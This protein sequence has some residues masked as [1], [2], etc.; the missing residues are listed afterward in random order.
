MDRVFEI[1]TDGGCSGN[2]GPG[3]WA[4]VL[5]M[6]DGDDE[7]DERISGGDPAT[8]NNRMELTA[9]IRALETVAKHHGEDERNPSVDVY[10]DSVYV[11]QGMMSW[12]AKWLRNG[13][14]TASKQPVKNRDLWQRLHGLTQNMDVRWH[15]VR[16]HA[17]NDKNEVCDA[18]VQ[19]RIKELKA[20][21]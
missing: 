21:K 13:W 4:F 6:H 20:R 7:I 17:G 12:L 19:R 3:A 1:Y 16:G 2:P 9:V 11:Q 18:M 14:R 10:T 8:T 15:W 5:S